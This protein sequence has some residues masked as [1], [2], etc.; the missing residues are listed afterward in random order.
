M[1]A[2]ITTATLALVFAACSAVSAAQSLSP[3]PQ[4]AEIAFVHS[5]Q[6]DLMARFPKALDAEQAGYFRFTNED[7][8]GSISYVNLH[9]QSADAQHPSQLW[10]DVHGNLLGADYSVLQSTSPKRPKLWGI[11]PARWLRI[12]EHLHYVLA[13]PA[14]NSDYHGMGTKKF[15]AA[16]GSLA[17]PSPATLVKMGL[18]KNTGQIAHFFVFPSIWDLQIWVKPNPNG[19]FAM[20]NPLVKPSKNA[21]HD[22]M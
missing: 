2:R 9:W 4:G 15:L 7:N 21:G 6:K 17:D 11:N 8:T 10:Y 16:G 13:G 14:K 20:M 1:L 19:A 3:K 5:V 22:S 18:I 12:D